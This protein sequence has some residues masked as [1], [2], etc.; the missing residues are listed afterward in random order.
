MKT[1]IQKSI[2]VLFM[3]VQFFCVAQ[4]VPDYYKTVAAYDSFYRANPETMLQMEGDYF[5][6]IRYKEFWK[7]RVYGQDSIKKG[8]P[9]LWLKAI[10]DYALEKD[11]YRQTPYGSFWY[12]LGPK[13]IQSQVSGL[14]STVFVDTIKDKTLRTI[15][16]GTNASGIWKTTDG[17]ENWTNITD[18]TGFPNLGITY[19][20]GDPNHPDVIYA[21]TGGNRLDRPEIITGYGIGILKSTDGGNT[22]GQFLNYSPENKNNVYKILI[23][24]TNSDRIYALVDSLVFR[25]DDGGQNWNKIFNLLERYQNVDDVKCLRDIE[26]HPSNTNILYT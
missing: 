24:P 20:V 8:S 26:M 9:E 2:V 25:T 7:D 22:W 11:K 1:I 19:I 16:L 17:G 13:N 3:T 4:I 12:Q 21:A 23:D 14:V 5:Q 10:S 18:N 15:Y 6:Y